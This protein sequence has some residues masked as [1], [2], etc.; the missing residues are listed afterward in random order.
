MAA[1]AALTGKLT[2]VREFLGSVTVTKTKIVTSPKLKLASAFD[3]LDVPQAPPAPQSHRHQ[4][5][6]FTPSPLKDLPGNSKKFT[7]AKGIAAPLHIENVD[8]DMIIPKQFCKTLKRTGLANALF[9]TIRKDPYTNKDTDFV[10]NR[11]PYDKA[12]VLV[13][14]GKNFGCGSSREHAVWSLNDFGIRCVIAPSFAE[15][16]QNNSMQNG[17]LPVALPQEDCHAL[18]QDAEAGLE[19]EVDLEKQEVRRSN[20]EGPI[21][22]VTDAFRRHC[23]LNGLDDIA[24]T[25]QKASVIEEFEQRRSREWPWLDGFGYEGIKIPVS[26][27]PSKKLDW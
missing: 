14:T 25:M 6:I 27:K 21:P 2:D 9:Y 12:K 16:F 22:F 10:L 1:A 23:L 15:I 20:G 17:M 26:L 4:S 5:T 11:I 24:L 13:V 18:A 7:V 3:F 8:T 19:L